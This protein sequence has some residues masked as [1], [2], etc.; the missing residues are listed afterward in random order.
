MQLVQL[1]H[2]PLD[3]FRQDEPQAQLAACTTI[4]DYKP[5]PTRRWRETA[6]TE[7]HRQM[8]HGSVDTDA[9]R[10]SSL[11]TINRRPRCVG[12]MLALPPSLQEQSVVAGAPL[13]APASHPRRH[14]THPRFMHKDRELRARSAVSYLDSP[15][16]EL[17][18]RRT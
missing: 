11:C 13:Q 7:S 10:S 9:Y 1:S 17:K 6:S 3:L 15:E 2:K 14:A 4:V 16:T 18:T 5:G 12:P 8:F